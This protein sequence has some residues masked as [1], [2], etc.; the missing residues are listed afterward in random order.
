LVGLAV[1]QADRPAVAPLLVVFGAGMI[2]LGVFYSRIEGSVEATKDGVKAVVREVERVA[3]EQGL[4]SEE[5]AELLTLAL[6]RY[7]PTPRK[8]THVLDAARRAVE[9]AAS[10]P[11]DSPLAVKRRLA[12]AVTA[13]L[14]SEGWAVEDHTSARPDIGYDM[15]GLREDEELLVELKAYRS[16][17]PS[18]VIRTAAAL[19][20]TTARMRPR[21]RTAVV[22]SARSPAPTASAL[23]LARQLGVE[24]HRIRGNGE[25]DVFVGQEA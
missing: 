24:I 9:E 21:V 6:E 20:E 4:S 14:T 18:P 8:P 22:L 15:L 13:W 25:R 17:L 5:F 3:L 16:P 7:Q 12:N 19:R 2:L 23:H 10:D 11:E 1:W